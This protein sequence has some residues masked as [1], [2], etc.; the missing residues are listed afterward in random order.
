[1]SDFRGNIQL[2]RMM[3]WTTALWRKHYIVVGVGYYCT[4]SVNEESIAFRGDAS[5]VKVVARL[6]NLS[7][8]DDSLLCLVTRILRLRGPAP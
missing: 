5:C 6:I 8:G 3:L 1:M 4:V 2:L 7:L